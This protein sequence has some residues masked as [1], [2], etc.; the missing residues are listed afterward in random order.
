LHETANAENTA[1]TDKINAF[2][3]IDPF[4]SY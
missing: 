3:I 1:K 4:F 2:F